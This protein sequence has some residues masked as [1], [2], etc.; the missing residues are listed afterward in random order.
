MKKFNRIVA[1]IFLSSCGIS[2]F[3][4]VM[5]K[6]GASGSSAPAVSRKAPVLSNV[7]P[8][9]TDTITSAIETDIATNNDVSGLNIDVTNKDGVIQLV[10]YAG[11]NT[12]AATLVEI[13]ESVPGVKDVNTSRLLAKN[14]QH[15][16]ADILISAK[17]KGTFIREKL[18]SEDSIGMPITVKTFNG[19]VFL[20]GS[21]KS[22][23]LVDKAIKMAKTVPGVGMV[24]SELIVTE[25]R[26]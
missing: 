23:E 15:T 24:K 3:A 21:V 19:R 25:A 6:S 10:G 1:I 4:D 5:S 22:Q 17:V 2:A 16:Q 7:A 12:Q 11:S 20:S 18:F 9:E 14:A 13:A 26:F 8:A